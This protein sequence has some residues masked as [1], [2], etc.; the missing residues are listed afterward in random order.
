V[1]GFVDGRGL[2]QLEDEPALEAGPVLPKDADRHLE[3]EVEATQLH[4]NRRAAHLE[5]D[6]RTP[7]DDT[8]VR[9]MAADPD[10]LVASR[11][12]RREDG[13]GARRQGDGEHSRS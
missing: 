8:L 2:E 10:D 1:P 4:G 5:R 6:F 7:P 11:K 13:G 3:V 12:D 9:Q